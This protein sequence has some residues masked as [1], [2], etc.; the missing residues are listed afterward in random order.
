MPDPIKPLRF[1]AIGLDHFHIHAQIALMLEQGCE[2]AAYCGEEETFFK[3][4]FAAE[5]PQARKVDD[6]R[7][8]LEDDCIAVVLSA[9]VNAERAPLGIEVM[10]HGKDFMVDKPGITS[11]DQLAEVRRVQAETGRIYS[12]CYGRLQS[13]ATIKAGELLRSG[14]I[15][16]LVNM[17]GLGPHRL[18]RARRPDWFFRREKFGGILTDL[19]SH[20]CDQ[21]LFLTGRL[22]AEIVSAAAAN[23]ANPDF[24]DFQDFGEVLLRTPD[25]TGYC[26]VDWFTPDGLPTW[27]DG[28]LT[29]IGTEGYMELRKNIDVAGAPGANHLFLVDRT[30]VQRIDCS[31]VAPPYGRQFVDDVMNRTET[32][33]PQAHCFRT[34]ELAIT[35]QMMAE[36][37]S[38]A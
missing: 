15:G 9:A 2:F 17:V 28:R 13:P 27:G 37:R 33:M 32:A 35:A 34:A 24:P 7:R 18:N 30:G 3:R 23:R 10:R 20:A 36:R 12:I 31:G 21:F 1:A 26:R 25:A 38:R 4:S 19:A 11:L 22:D 5:Y 14:A 29:L 6:P 8:I 16:R